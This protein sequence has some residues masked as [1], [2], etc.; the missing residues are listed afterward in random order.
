MGF[1]GAEIENRYQSSYTC[2]DMTLDE[3]QIGGRVIIRSVGGDRAFRR[4]L[5]EFGLIPGTEVEIKRIAPL[6]DPMELLARG[7]CVSI[8]RREAQ[9][10]DVSPVRELDA[11]PGMVGAPVNALMSRER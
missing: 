10:I 5:M 3:A 1:S 7:A 11:V 6:G 8:R 4:R 9:T 2:E